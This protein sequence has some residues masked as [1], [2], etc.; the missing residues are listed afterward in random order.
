MQRFLTSLLKHCPVNPV[1]NLRDP[2]F[3]GRQAA[4]QCVAFLQGVKDTNITNFH[5]ALQVC[6]STN[7]GLHRID[8]SVVVDPRLVAGTAHAIRWTLRKV[9]TDCGVGDARCAGSLAS[10]SSCSPH[11]QFPAAVLRGGPESCVVV[12]HQLRCNAFRV[13]ALLE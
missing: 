10:W 5:A 7:T 4:P 11:A 8:E 2:T 6:N 1:T 9:A 12:R 3:C 13:V